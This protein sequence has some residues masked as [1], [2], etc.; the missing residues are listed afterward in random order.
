MSKEIQERIH[1]LRLAMKEN[2]VDAYMVPT[3][4]F[5]GSEYV[6]EYFKC[7]EYLSGFTGSAGTLL[8]TEDFAGLW[9]DGR[10]FLQAEAQLAGSGIELMRQREEGVPTIAEYLERNLPALSTLGFDGR[11]VGWQEAMDFSAKYHLRTDLDLAGQVWCSRPPLK[12]EKIYP[13]SKDVTG[14]T[15]EEKLTRIRKEME[16]AGATYHLVTCLEDIAW[17]YNLRGSDVKYTPVFFAYA[18]VGKTEDVLYVLNEDLAEIENDVLPKTTVVRPYF[19]IFEDIKQLKNEKLLADKNTV[20][21]ALLGNLNSDVEVID[22]KNPAELMK[23]IKNEVEIG[24]TKNAHIKDGVAMVNFIK[25]VKEK[26]AGK[27]AVT[28]LDAAE[29]ADGFRAQQKGFSQ[30]SFETISGYGENGAIVHYSVT[31]ETNKEIKAEGFLLVDS[32][33]Q[34]EDGTTDI[35]RT[36]ATGHLTDEMRRNYTL[37]LK[38]HIAVARAKFSPETTGAELDAM[39][40]RALK[41][42]GLNY[43]HGTGHG[44]GHL[45]SVHE[46]PVSISPRASEE[47]FSPGMITSDEPGVY[48]EGK[49]GIR[50]ENEVLC[51]KADETGFLGFQPLTWCPWE[52]QAI[53]VGLLDAE[54]ICWIN[55]Y[56]KM[57]YEILQ[58]YLDDETREWLHG[59]TAPLS[60]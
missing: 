8:V 36:I 11:I 50:L 1:M 43:N 25:W 15:S 27:A 30:P 56:H 13:V 35:T 5:H 24:C 59:E 33:G 2:G 53:D 34:Y 58:S 9:T 22:E 37:V 14:E 39:A 55:E 12:A 49:Y 54:E 60:V 41:E 46:G 45:L 31:P 48:L 6:N 42:A 32:G 17:M 38:G 20:S 3:T 16:R 57:V 7:R 21:F 10:Y 4:D 47:T 23:A 29:A 44:V 19:Q 18:L 51:V 52:R 40:R 28:E 26:A